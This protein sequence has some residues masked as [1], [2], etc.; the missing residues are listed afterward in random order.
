MMLLILALLP[1]TPI[2]W[3]HALDIFGDS[4]DLIG[5]VLIALVF[6][7]LAV[8]MVRR[9]TVNGLLGFF[10]LAAFA[11]MYYIL[12]QYL[13]RYP[14]DRV[15]FLEYG[16]LAYLLRRA[17]RFDF[18]SAKSYALSFLIGGGFGAVDEGI[19]YVLSNRVFEV[20]D[21]LINVIAAALGLLV[22]AVL[23]RPE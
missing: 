9:R 10:A 21:I 13:C 12:L 17:F 11:V 5:Y 22:V 15:H 7:C 1:L 4:F 8:Y 16:L 19:Q 18:S 14:G 6:V 2:L 23:V 3:E 20:R